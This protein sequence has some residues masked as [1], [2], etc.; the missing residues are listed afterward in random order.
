MPAR[1][2]LERLYGFAEP[3]MTVADQFAYTCL[4]CGARSE[5]GDRTPEHEADCG[6]WQLWRTL[7]SPA[8]RRL[9]AQVGRLTA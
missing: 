5:D 2:L 6:Y 8:G 9:A 3:T 1:T 4:Y 7:A